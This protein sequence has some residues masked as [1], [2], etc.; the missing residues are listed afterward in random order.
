MTREKLF[1][2]VTRSCG[3]DAIIPPDVDED[4]IN[5]EYDSSDIYYEA[6]YYRCPACSKRA[7]TR[8]PIEAHLRSPTHAPKIYMCPERHGGCGARFRGLGGLFQHMIDAGDAKLRDV[9]R[10]I[11]RQIRREL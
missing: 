1:G 6:G 2:I 9:L 11:K 8:Q 7:E 3:S 4:S 5:S 10:P